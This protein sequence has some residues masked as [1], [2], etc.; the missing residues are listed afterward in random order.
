MKEGK[1]ERGQ[2]LVEM[3]MVLPVL[4]IF[5]IGVAEMGSALRNYLIVVNSSREGCRFAARGYFSDELIGERVVV[6]GGSIRAGDFV[7]ST[8]SIPF[9]R[10]HNYDEYAA[11]AG[12]IVTHIVVSSTGTVLSRTQWYTGVVLA[13]GGAITE[14]VLI[15]G[16]NSQLDIGEITT[17]H[18][19]STKKISDIRAAA[20]VAERENHTV[21]VEVFFLH[22]LL[23]DL[24]LVPLPNPIQMYASTEMRIWGE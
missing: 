12:V 24:P 21:V 17:R 20:M 7:T 2:S 18:V 14:T 1:K 8:E 13:E 11:N 15:A 22:P 9:L 5:L 4:L 19:D 23:L 6:A 3:V 10:T 16:D